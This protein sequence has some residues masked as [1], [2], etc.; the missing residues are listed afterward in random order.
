MVIVSLTIVLG[1]P[2]PIP[3]EEEQL[4]KE[5]VQEIPKIYNTPGEIEVQPNGEPILPED[6]K[7]L[8]KKDVF[9]R[10]DRSAAYTYYH[11]GVYYY[12]PKFRWN[13]YYYYNYYYWWL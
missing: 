5:V 8:F 12:P 1:Y 7:Q 3:V 13:P 6:A 10:P 2:Q 4:E 11:P 9:I